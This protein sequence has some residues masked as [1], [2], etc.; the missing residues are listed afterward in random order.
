MWKCQVEVDIDRPVHRKRNVPKENRRTLE[1]VKGLL[2][3]ERQEA[4]AS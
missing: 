4:A 2:E 3:R 1:R